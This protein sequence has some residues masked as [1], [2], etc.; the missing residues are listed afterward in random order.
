MRRAAIVLVVV[1]SFAG[2]SADDRHDVGR[3]ARAPGSGPPIEA[4]P[5]ETPD[6]AALGDS[7]TTPPPPPEDAG[8]APTP[9]DLDAVLEPIRAASGLPAL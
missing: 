7:A 8:V 1:G 5:P 2:C 9:D 4:G 3:D 6:S